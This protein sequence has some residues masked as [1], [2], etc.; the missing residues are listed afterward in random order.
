MDDK[1][2]KSEAKPPVEKEPVIPKCKTCGQLLTQCRCTH[3]DL[4]K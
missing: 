1:K 3:N 4:K 2:N